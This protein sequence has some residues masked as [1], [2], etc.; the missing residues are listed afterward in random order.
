MKARVMVAALA[1]AGLLA[2]TGCGSNPQVAAYVGGP[3]SAVNL[4]V[5]QSE[6]DTIANEIAA[7]TSDAYDTGAS[8]AANVMQ[9]MV[10]S[11]IAGVVAKDKGITVTDAQRD[12]FYATV[13]LYPA[14]AKNPVTAGF[15][16]RFADA[17]TILTD[18]AAAT[19]FSDLLAKTPVRV[20]PRFGVWD[21]T[22]HGLVDGSTGSLS[23][24]APTKG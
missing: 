21:D 2:L 9:I 19:A 16:V 18:Q 14:L 1:T 6:V 17:S 11:E 22:K 8:F 3:D 7:T 10:Q 12:T 5:T 15:M 23:E 4:T 20:N 13:E 24:A